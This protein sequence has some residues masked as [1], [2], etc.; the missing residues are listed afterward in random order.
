MSTTCRCLVSIALFLVLSPI[1][2]VVQSQIDPYKI[3]N[4]PKH[5]TQKEIRKAFKTLAL[6]YHPD[7]NTPASDE[8]RMKKVT[9]AYEILG[10]ESKRKTYDNEQR[11]STIFSGRGFRHSGATSDGIGASLTT[12]NFQN[13]L[14][15]VND[16]PWLI[17][18]CFL[19]QKEG[20]RERELVGESSIHVLLKEIIVIYISPCYAVYLIC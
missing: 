6:K 1:A 19:G 8:D 13:L 3:L 17:L 10:D 5:A 18:V 15:N 7:R 14:Y 11:Q 2:V 12:H 9:A 16:L 20:E 4:V